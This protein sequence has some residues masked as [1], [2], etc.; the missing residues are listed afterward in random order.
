MDLLFMYRHTR[1][2]VAETLVLGLSCVCHIHNDWL[3][4]CNRY[5][6]QGCFWSPTSSTETST[7][8]CAVYHL[9]CCIHVSVDATEVKNTTGDDLHHPF[10]K[11][12]NRPAYQ[13]PRLKPRFFHTYTQ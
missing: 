7:L 12:P 11:V 8:V 4:L 1:S 6:R 2:V 13:W 10:I 5:S 3:M 9:Y